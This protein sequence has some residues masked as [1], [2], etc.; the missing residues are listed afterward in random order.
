MKV[1][2]KSLGFLFAILFLIS[3]ILQYNDPDPLL[4]M[5]IWAGA[6][7]IALAVA[8]DKVSF[9]IPLCSGICAFIGFFYTYPEKFEGFEIGVGDIKNV[10]EGREAF[11]LL[12]IAIVLLLFAYRIWYTKKLKV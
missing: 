1:L 7:V 10:E 2:F 5:I 12:A 8:L 9:L 3:A 11:G 4:W 6:G